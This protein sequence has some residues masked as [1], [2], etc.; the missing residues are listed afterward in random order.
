[1][2]LGKYLNAFINANQIAEGIKNKVFKKEHVEAEA[3]LRWAICKEC[4]SLDKEG[5]ECFAPGTQPC[6]G[7][8][9]CSLGFKTRSLSSECPLGKWK[10]VMDEETE[11]KLNEYLDGNGSI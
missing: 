5:S 2:N 3:A 11:A 7:E 10:A 6:C 8:C 1:M 9:G 4:P